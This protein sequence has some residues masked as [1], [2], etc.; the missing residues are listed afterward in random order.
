MSVQ[1]TN[2]KVLVADD[3]FMA[4][5]MV[6]NVLQQRNVRDITMVSNGEEAIAAII[7]ARE[8][9]APFHI[10]FLDWDMP[11]VSGFDVLGYFR[12]RKE[13]A[14]TAFVML[15]AVSSQNEVLQAVKAG[16][17]SYIVKPVSRGRIDEKF[18]EIC[19]WVRRNEVSS[20]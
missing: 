20:A 15:T 1:R 7:G 13:Y 4:R 18:T 9:G 6:V 8:A 11:N 19:D 14:S 16:A 2:F 17:T 5:Q 12:T 3:H 10:V